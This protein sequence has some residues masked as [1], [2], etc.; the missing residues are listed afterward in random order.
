MTNEV[1]TACKTCGAH[2]SGPTDVQPTSHG[3]CKS[4]LKTQSPGAYYF[5]RRREIS[6]R[7]AAFDSSAATADLNAFFFRRPS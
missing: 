1:A 5:G 3:I 4:C 6:E 7:L 2:I